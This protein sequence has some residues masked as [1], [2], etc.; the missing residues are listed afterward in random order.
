MSI[1]VDLNCDMGE[2]SHN[3]RVGNDEAVLPFISSANI[4]CGF[5][6]GTPAVM[7]KTVVMALENQVAIGAHPGFYD[8]D[9]FGRR[10]ITISPDEAYEI[11]VYQIGA[12]EAFTRSEGGKLHHVKPH[13]ALYNMAAKDQELSKAIARAVFKVNPELI[14]YGLSGSELIKAGATIGLRT[15]S[16]AFADRTYQLD[17]SL[18]PRNIEGA[19]I[20]DFEHVSKQILSLVKNKSILT[21]SGEPLS[22]QAET[23]CIHGDGSHAAEFAKRLRNTLIEN[24]I[25]VSA[26]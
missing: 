6:A 14:L 16:E 18:T 3:T 1:S 2:S 25:S 4:A 9:G 10:E 19:V 8:R 12:L 22:L 20:E 5:H 24:G 15:A 23:I 13:G 7:R 17:G 21:H 11:I 26:P